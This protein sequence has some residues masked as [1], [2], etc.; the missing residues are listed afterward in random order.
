MF[1]INVSVCAFFLAC[2]LAVAAVNRLTS[3]HSEP[4][5]IICGT[6]S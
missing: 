1:R 5:Q 6:T 3:I 2:V 4:L